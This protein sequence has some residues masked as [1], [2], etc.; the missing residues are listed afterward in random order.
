MAG[1]LA[2]LVLNSVISDDVDDVELRVAFDFDR[3][4]G[5]LGGAGV[6]VGRDRGV[7]FR[8]RTDRHTARGGTATGTVRQDREAPGARERPGPRSSRTTSPG[9][10][11]P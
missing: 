3:A 4:G 5:R 11:L 9:S 1:Y 10:R 7:P 6:P 2:G 8:E